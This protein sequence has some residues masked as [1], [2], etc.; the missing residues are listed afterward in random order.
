MSTTESPQES[1]HL[2]VRNA[3]YNGHDALFMYEADDFRLTDPRFSGKLTV[4]AGGTY[5]R[6]KKTLAADGRTFRVH[7]D[8]SLSEVVA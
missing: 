1:K 6:R 7:A 5:D 8:W 3:D 2:L 4:I